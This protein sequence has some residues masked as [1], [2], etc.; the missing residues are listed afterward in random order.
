MRKH[1]LYDI[2]DNLNRFPI[3]VGR[4]NELELLNSAILNQRK[5]V[6]AITGNNATG[7]TTLWMQ[8]LRNHGV[9][10][11]KNTEA[12]YLH[13]SSD[14]FPPLNKDTKLVVLEDLSFDFTREISGR[15]SSFIKENQNKQ[16][17]L[18]ST[19]S[20]FVKEF[21][22][23]AHI[24]LNALPHAGSQ[25]FLLQALETMLPDGDL[26]KVAHFTQ[27]NPLLLNLVV[28]HINNGSKNIDALFKLLS[29]DIKY[30][31]IDQI[32]EIRK[33]I[34][35]P[36]FIHVANDIRVINGKLLEAIQRNHK[37]IFDLT[38]RQFEQFV[39]ELMEKRGYRV[40][41]TKATRDGGKDLII[42]NHVDIGNF[43]F[44]VECKKYAPINPVGVNLVRELAGTVLA[45]RVTAGIMITSSYFSPDA[46]N[47]SNQL[48]HQLS[49]IDYLKLKDWINEC[50]TSFRKLP[51]R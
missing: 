48:K 29:E 45:D 6:V 36:N 41:L 32:G 30:R 35:Q 46:I 28:N 18:V 15:I 38:P 16:F 1:N 42:A 26:A 17:I 49:L 23:E 5:R 50:D 7:K 44:Y 21:N 4:E 27:G 20:D 37:A 19:F 43:I 12:V 13:R 9:E 10:L 33:S 3:V 34:E 22:P 25:Q 39:A 47:Y 31:S 8:F 11:A 14:E 40:D 2:F 24:H 51:L